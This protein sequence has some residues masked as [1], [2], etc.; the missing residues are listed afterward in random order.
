[1]AH[2]DWVEGRLGAGKEE[3][4]MEKV[5][6]RSKHSLFSASRYNRDIRVKDFH[7]LN[8]LVPHSPASMIQL[9]MLRVFHHFHISTQQAIDE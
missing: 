8:S 1:M 7:P 4:R 9:I 6:V 2:D 3:W 5:S